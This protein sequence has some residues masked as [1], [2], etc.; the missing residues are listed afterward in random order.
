[1]YRPHLTSLIERHPASLAAR[2]PNPPEERFAALSPSCRHGRGSRAA[3]DAMRALRV[4]KNDIALLT[5]LCDLGGVWPVM[6][7]TAALSEAADA[8]VTARR[9]LPL[10]RS[11][12]AGQWSAQWRRSHL[13]AGYIVL[14]MGKYGAC[15]LNYSCDIDLIVFY[16]PERIA[17]A[18][19]S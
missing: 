10:P 18:R 8:A 11:G 4:F 16:D 12:G 13:P 14:G 2:F 15:E 6:T 3:P 9:R 7:V 19:R 5:A 1:M 17:P